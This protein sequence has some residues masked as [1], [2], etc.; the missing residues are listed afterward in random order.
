MMDLASIFEET[1]DGVTLNL[2]KPL[3]IAVGNA[4]ITLRPSGEISLRGASI[5][6]KSTYITIEGTTQAMLSTSGPLT[7]AGSQIRL[8]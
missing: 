8:L 1:S 2:D 7:L 3:T 4:A 6:A 5:T